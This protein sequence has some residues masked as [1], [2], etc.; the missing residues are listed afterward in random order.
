MYDGEPKFEINAGFKDK[1]YTKDTG[2]CALGRIVNVCNYM[3]HPTTMKYL[4][5]TL[6]LLND[7]L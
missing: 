1:K 5:Q 3:A 6:S 4:T 2:A 7:V